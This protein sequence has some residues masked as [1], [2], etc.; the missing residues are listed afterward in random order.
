MPDLCKINKTCSIIHSNKTK[1]PPKVAKPLPVPLI[2]LQSFLSTIAVD[3]LTFPIYIY[4]ISTAFINIAMTS[5]IA[6]PIK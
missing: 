1:N 2:L 4:L 6:P 3:L 5:P